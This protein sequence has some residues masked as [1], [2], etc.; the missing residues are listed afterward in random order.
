M[1]FKLY[2]IINMHRKV[3]TLQSFVPQLWPKMLHIGYT[4]SQD[5]LD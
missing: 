2:D 4:L 3:L 1:F 5:M